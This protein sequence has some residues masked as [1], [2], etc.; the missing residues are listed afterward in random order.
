MWSAAAG[1]IGPGCRPPSV[2]DRSIE[3][4][5]RRSQQTQGPDHSRRSVLGAVGG[6]GVRVVLHRLSA[7]HTEVRLHQRCLL[8]NSTESRRCIE[9]EY[10]AASSSF[11]TYS[12]NVFTQETQRS[13]PVLCMVHQ[14]DNIKPNLVNHRF[15]IIFST[16][17]CITIEPGEGARDMFA[18]TAVTRVRHFDRL[19]QSSA[20]SRS[21]DDAP[22][23]SPYP[24]PPP[25]PPSP[26][27][28]PSP[29]P[30]PAP[31]PAPS[32]SP[33]ID[34]LSESALQP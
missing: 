7:G 29:S 22:S 16:E 27:L 24:S 25:S 30:F 4:R 6:T 23:P 9:L 10:I 8:E 21:R 2:T 32:Q 19:L 1:D 26:S 15:E 34:C 3:T 33:F 12:L 20:A 14:Y 31:F 13:F 28:S 11:H 18:C 17:H 5:P